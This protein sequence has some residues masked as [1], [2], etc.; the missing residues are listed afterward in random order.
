MAAPCTAI[1]ERTSRAWRLIRI[2]V[3]RFVIAIRN[4]SMRTTQKKVILLAIV[5]AILAFDFLSSSQNGSV[6]SSAPAASLPAGVDAV[7]APPAFR[8]D[9]PHVP[10][11]LPE[12]QTLN[13]P[14]E[15]LFASLSQRQPTP[16]TA[17]VRVAPSAPPL[18]FRFAGRLLHDGKLQ[19]FLSSGDSPIPVTEGEVLDGV[20]RIESIADDRITLVYLPLNQKESIPL[21]FPPQ[22][23]DA[24][25]PAAADV[26]RS[27]PQAIGTIPAASVITVERSR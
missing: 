5:G 19:V 2:P 18:P 27:E 20:Y 13:E 17:A 10:L 1:G 8:G 4:E 26:V 6:R 25:V 22:A 23:V 7:A 16:R 21:T 12:R 24:G 14:G 9:P 11:D 15:D 3:D